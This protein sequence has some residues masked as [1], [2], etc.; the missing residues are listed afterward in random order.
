MR[1]IAVR[2]AGLYLN[3]PA[4]VKGRSLLHSIPPAPAFGEPVSSAGPS[5]Q[6]LDLLARRR[7]GGAALLVGPGPSHQEIRVLLQL[8]ARVPDHGKLNPWRFVVLEGPAKD[9]LADAIEPFAAE[10]PDPGKAQ[11]VLAKLRAPPVSIMV[12]SRVIESKID[13]WEQVLSSGAVCMNLLIA[14]EAMGYA[15][16]WITDWYSYDPRTRGLLGLGDGER[17]AGFIHLGHHASPPLERVR[18]EVETLIDWRVD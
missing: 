14:A 11:A 1:H 18:P 4:G 2:V 15:A 17:V 5:A 7:S 6:T 9:A 16:N 3:G 12:V 10:Q 8:A 13:E